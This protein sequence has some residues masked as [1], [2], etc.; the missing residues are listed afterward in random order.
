M[1]FATLHT[2]VFNTA[3]ESSEFWSL[4]PLLASLANEVC[5]NGVTHFCACQ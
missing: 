4:P 1:F 5:T 3:A 2:E